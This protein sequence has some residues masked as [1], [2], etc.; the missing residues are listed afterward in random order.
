MGPVATAPDVVRRALLRV[1]GAATQE[2]RAAA[3]DPAADP[4][5]WRAALFAAAPLILD[6]YAP[7]SATLALD[8][9]GE[10]RDESNARRRFVATPRLTVTDG[11]VAAIVARATADVVDLRREIE[12]EAESIFAEA[13]LAVEAEMERLVADAFR[14]TITGNAQDDPESAGWKRFA[15]PEACKFCLMLA[16]RG[17]VYTRETAR[18]AA[19]G[20]LMRGGRKGGN[21]MCIA[22]PEFGGK[23]TWAEAEP[24]QYLASRRK[25][26]AADRA[27][28]RDY[29]NENYPDA[30]G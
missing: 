10:L 28:L 25:R 23:E 26:S 15:R 24:I 20:A 29:L 14:D 13:S 22:G 3:P 6:E 18:F 17:A 27:R 7:A 30:P 19:H 9:F 4:E 21:C 16:A 11:D 1:S 12:A 8:W 2:L 5:A